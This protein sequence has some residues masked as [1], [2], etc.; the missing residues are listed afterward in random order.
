MTKVSI[1]KQSTHFLLLIL[2]LLK[3][4]MINLTKDSNNVLLKL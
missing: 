3:N 1:Y 2:Q 4:L